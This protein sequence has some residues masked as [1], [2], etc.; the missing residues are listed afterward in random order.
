MH[1]Q[2]V[3]VASVKRNQ[4]ISACNSPSS[5]DGN[6]IYAPGPVFWN[7]NDWNSLALAGPPW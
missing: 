2:K 7:L 6:L 4:R 5:A 1:Q 3:V